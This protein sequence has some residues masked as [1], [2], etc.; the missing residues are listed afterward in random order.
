MALIT[1]STIEN[2]YIFQAVSSGVCSSE[3]IVFHDVYY[4]LLRL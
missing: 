1:E 3:N 2:S 4:F